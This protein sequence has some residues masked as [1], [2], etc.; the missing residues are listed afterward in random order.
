M[1]GLTVSA[2]PGASQVGRFTP[3]ELAGKVLAGYQ[4]WF[5]TPND[6]MGWGWGHWGQPAPHTLD[7][8]N[9]PD[10]SD[11]PPGSLVD[12]G[13]T[14]HD[15]QPARLFSSA[16]PAVTDL[17]FQWM[18]DYGI[19]GAFVQWFVGGVGTQFGPMGQDKV[20]ANRLRLLENACSSAEKYGRSFAITFDISGIEHCPCCYDNAAALQ[21]GR[22]QFPAGAL[23]LRG[24]QAR[25]TPLGTLTMQTD[26]NLVFYGANRRALWASNTARAISPD[27]TARFQDDGNLVLYQG[28]RA[29][30]AS[31]T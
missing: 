25:V 31:N 21:P 18:R 30:W 20:M 5:D 17:H 4:G 15:G 2:R 7:V 22:P 1:A 11:Y 10:I 9:W 13:L 29:Y 3:P 26:G 19:D 28:S 12:C 6:G 16:D 14:L 24:G 23:S 27:Y 8:D